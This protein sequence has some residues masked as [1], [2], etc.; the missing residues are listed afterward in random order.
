MLESGEAKTIRELATRE[1]GA[2]QPLRAKR[3]IVTG[4]FH[5]P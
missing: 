2:L 3:T 1:G 5:H 4:R